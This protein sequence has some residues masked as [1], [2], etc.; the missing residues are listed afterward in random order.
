MQHYRPSNENERR[1]Q[2]HLR[3]VGR[4]IRYHRK[5]AAHLNQQ[6]APEARRED[7]RL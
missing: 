3:N 2:E 4:L 1:T 7:H 6:N 5:R